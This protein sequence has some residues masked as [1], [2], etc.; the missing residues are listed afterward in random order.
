MNKMIVLVGPSGGGKSALGKEVFQALSDW[1]TFITHTTRDMRI[2]EIQDVSYHFV[3]NKTFFN[4]EKV[5]FDE[6]PKGSGKYYGL[7]VKEVQDK[8]EK[9]N[10]YCVMS[11]QGA[12]A[13]KEKFPETK[14]IFIYAPID[15]LEERM[16]S[17]GDKED[18]IQERLQNIETSKEL[19]NAKYADLVVEN[20]NLEEAKNK[21]LSYISSI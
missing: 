17:R 13:L 21:I 6:Y 9:G 18:K 1:F 7:S 12:L 14:I 20:I 3:N 10:C 16:R 11:I 5:E 4:T 19:E 15:I 8:K 2:G